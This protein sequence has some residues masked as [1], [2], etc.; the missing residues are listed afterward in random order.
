MKRLK[1][2]FAVT[3]LFTAF[4]SCQKDEV[5]PAIDEISMSQ[6]ETQAEETLNDIDILVDEA[7]DSNIGILKS[8]SLESLSYLTDC[9]VVTVNKTAVPQVMTIDFGTSCTGKDG[10]KRS[11]KIIVTSTSFNTFPSVRDKSFDN[12]FVDSK[13]V[14]GSV[15][16]TISK[17][18]ENNIRTAVILENITITFPDGEGTA[19]RVANLTRQYQRNILANKEDNQ[20]VSWGT[21][22]FTRISGVKVTKTITSGDALV[23]K[24]ACHHMVSGTVTFTTSNDRKW[25]I[26]YGNGDCDN[27]A[28]LTSGDKTKEITIR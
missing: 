9:P 16:K 20:V 27:K 10:K 11:G 7:V 5:T 22:D 23:F 13:K 8:A 1:V 25:S 14:E 6:Q 12:F 21:V 4:Q 26:N 24:L 17:D 3:I 15:T 2:F 19:K 28:T 18:Q